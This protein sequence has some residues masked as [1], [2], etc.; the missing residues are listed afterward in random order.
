MR[1]RRIHY[2]E[3]EGRENLPIVI[4]YVKNYLKTFRLP[5]GDLLPGRPNKIVCMTFRGEGPMLAYHQLFKEDVSIVAV[6]FP[7]TYRVVS[8]DSITYS[9]LPDKVRKFF[10]SVGIRVIRTRLPFDE[11][12]GADA[13]NKEMTALKRTLA[14]FGGSIPLAI[15]AVLQATD[16]SEVMSGEQVI[17][18]TSDTAL[19]V[20][21]STTKDFLN[22]SSGLRVNE[23][24]C[25]PRR[26]TIAPPIPKPAG[27][28]PAPSA[29]VSSDV[30]KPVLVI[31]GKQPP[32]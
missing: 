21:A 5:T 19:V 11:I 14:V 2:F 18:V 6:L 13:H 10:D 20:T 8:K 31:E 15:Q 1:S 12:T 3:S 23:I 29:P 24:L 4:K 25:K 28:L 30:G 26:Y 27:T 7:S 16:S 32:Q 17:A 9:E 22:P